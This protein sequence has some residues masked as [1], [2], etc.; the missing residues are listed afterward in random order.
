MKHSL[1]FFSRQNCET[2]STNVEC[3]CIRIAIGFLLH[4]VNI[5]SCLP[6]AITKVK[7]RETER[8]K[9]RKGRQEGTR[10]YM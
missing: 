2:R 6:V 7:G 5:L 9:E 8:E 1:D 3:S 4:A 10:P